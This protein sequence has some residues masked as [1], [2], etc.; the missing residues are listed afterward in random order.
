[1]GFSLKGADGFFYTNGILDT[2][3]DAWLASVLSLLAPERN[4]GQA[5][6]PVPEILGNV[7]GLQRGVTGLDINAYTRFRQKGVVAGR[8]DRATG[9]YTFQSG[10]TTSLVTGQKNIAR[11]RMADFIE[12][13]LADALQKFSKQPLTQGLKDASVGEVDA[14][15]NGMLS[16]NNPPAQRISAYNV[17]DKSGNTP[18]LEG[19]GVFVIIANVRTLASADFIVVQANIGEQVVVTAT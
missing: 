18:T 3:G 1:V 16:T 5:T 4:P 7:L 19:Q 11:R 17:D 14:F 6:S 12:D 8:Y 15:L 13:S 9:G 2:H 10:I